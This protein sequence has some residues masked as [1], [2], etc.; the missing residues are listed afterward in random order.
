MR[1][2]AQGCVLYPT[3]PIPCP[4]GLVVTD[5]F[6]APSSLLVLQALG[7]WSSN[8]DHFVPQLVLWSQISPL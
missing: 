2:E 4:P 7:V 5:P 6:P 3:P 8:S 1:L